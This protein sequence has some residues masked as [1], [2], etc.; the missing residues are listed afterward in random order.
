MAKEIYP[1]VYL[2]RPKQENLIVSVY[3]G[4]CED[5]SSIIVS[6]LHEDGRVE[7]VST[8]II[9]RAKDFKE[10]KIKEFLSN[11]ENNGVEI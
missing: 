4:Q 5:I 11:I 9:G 8:K 3:F 7:I 2:V 6:R 10:E 1:R